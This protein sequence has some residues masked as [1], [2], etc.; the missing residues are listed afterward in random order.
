MHEVPKRMVGENEQT[1]LVKDYYRE[2]IRQVMKAKGDSPLK[3]RPDYELPPDAGITEV[4]QYTDSF[5]AG[6]HDTVDHYRYNRYVETLNLLTPSKVR[7]VHVDIGCG[8]GLFSWAF[9]DWATANGIE[10]KRIRL[11][12]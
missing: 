12:G 9:L 2:A 7:Q 8:V 11:F 4:L 6:T 5:V 10:H 1:A 3:D